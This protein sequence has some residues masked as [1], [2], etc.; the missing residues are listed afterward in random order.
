MTENERE[1]AQSE[2]APDAE[3]KA[4]LMLLVGCVSEVGH[5]GQLQ[6]GGLRLATAEDLA[7]AGLVDAG[8]ALQFADDVA[9]VTGSMLT[10]KP[11]AVGGR[12]PG[13]AFR[14]GWAAA[15]G[16]LADYS[17]KLGMLDDEAYDM[18]LTTIRYNVNNA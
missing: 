11:P 14:A 12:V 1:K 3:G 10:S 8:G 5:G 18:A 4:Q 9:R 6:V 16:L 17:K 7:R 13:K 15:L 2:K